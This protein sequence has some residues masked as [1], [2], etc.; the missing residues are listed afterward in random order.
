MRAQIKTEAYKVFRQPLL[1]LFLAFPILLFI[2]EVS[3]PERLMARTNVWQEFFNLDHSAALYSY[4]MTKISLFNL[5]L[6]VLFCFQYVRMEQQNS[7]TNALFTL[8]V[9]TST[10]YFSKVTVL[11]GVVLLNNLIIFAI[12][13]SAVL[14]AKAGT[15]PSCGPFLYYSSGC[16][17]L[18]CFHYTL[19]NLTRNLIYYLCLFIALFAASNLLE[20]LFLPHSYCNGFATGYPESKL[21]VYFPWVTPI[22]TVFSILLGYVI[23]KRINLW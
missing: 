8:P 13:S 6:S 1:I 17:M 11:C 22:Y 20:S 9:K 23:F 10:L 3:F 15:I 4:L 5:I 14:V 19:A 16:I 21:A 2:Y 12:L 7:C 18:A